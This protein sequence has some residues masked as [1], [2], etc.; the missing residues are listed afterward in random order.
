MSCTPQICTPGV[1]PLGTTYTGYRLQY[2]QQLCTVLYIIC[3]SLLA[4]NSNSQYYYYYQYLQ[5]QYQTLKDNYCTVFAT[6]A[7]YRLLL[8]LVVL[9]YWLVSCTCRQLVLVQTVSVVVPYVLA[10][11]VV[12]VVIYLVSTTPCLE[13]LLS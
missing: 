3:C 2:R 12:L 9:M 13:T 11:L 5:Q 6:R 7:S 4:T 8:Q 1:Q 10:P